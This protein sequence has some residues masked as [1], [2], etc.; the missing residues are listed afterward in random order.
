MYMVSLLTH[1]YLFLFIITFLYQL[2]IE[3][4][5]LQKQCQEERADKVLAIQKVT[6]YFTANNTLKIILLKQHEEYY[7]SKHVY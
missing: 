5:E 2:Q 3:A 4:A 1:C 7:F 6:S